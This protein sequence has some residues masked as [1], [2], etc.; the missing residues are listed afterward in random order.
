MHVKNR[1]FIIT[2]SIS[3]NKKNPESDKV[4][5]NPR[6]TR[7]HTLIHQTANTVDT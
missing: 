7:I 2:H 1:M 6:K 5:N 3:A 4:K